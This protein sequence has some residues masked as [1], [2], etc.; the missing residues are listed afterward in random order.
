MKSIYILAYFPLVFHLTCWS[1]FT[2]KNDSTRSNSI[3]FDAVPILEIP[4]TLS[5]G[6]LHFPMRNNND[7]LPYVGIGGGNIVLY[8]NESL[9]LGFFIGF[10]FGEYAQRNFLGTYLHQGLQK[11]FDVNMTSRLRNFRFGVKAI[12]QTS[13]KRFKPYAEL[14]LSNMTMFTR[15][16]VTEIIPGAENNNIELRPVVLNRTIAYHINTGVDINLMKKSTISHEDYKGE[17]FFIHLGFGYI[18][19]A[20]LVEHIDLNK[21]VTNLEEVEDSNLN[22]RIINSNRTNFSTYVP[23][24]A[25]YLRYLN[26]SFGI[27]YRI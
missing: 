18:H 2:A 10:S 5:R 1:Q 25:S 16:S 12:N 11:S 26:F 23:H 7:D 27:S 22:Y 13:R 14:Y 24:Y 15:L 17:G 19:G 6:D 8:P 9:P 4:L 20:K 21:A 3:D